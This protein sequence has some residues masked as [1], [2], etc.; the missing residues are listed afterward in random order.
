MNVPKY[1][2]DML[3]RADVRYTIDYASRTIH[4]V[5]MNRDAPLTSKEMNSLINYCVISD[6]PFYLVLDE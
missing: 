4:L 2:E 6:F 1:I 3:N 5:S